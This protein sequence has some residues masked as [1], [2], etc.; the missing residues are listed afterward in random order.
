MRT[1]ARFL[2]VRSGSWSSGIPLLGVFLG[3]VPFRWIRGMISCVVDIE[4]CL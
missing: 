3:F 4:L 2:H 1:R